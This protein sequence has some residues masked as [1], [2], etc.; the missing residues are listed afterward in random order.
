MQS[1]KYVEPVIDAERSLSPRKSRLQSATQ[2][3]ARRLHTAMIAKGMNQSDLARATWKK[4]TVDKR[5]YSQPVGKDRI[6]VYLKGRVLPDAQNLKRLA[7]ALDMKV[8]DLAPVGGG[9]PVDRDAPDF[10]FSPAA[11]GY[12]LVELKYV[13]PAEDAATIMGIIARLEAEKDPHGQKRNPNDP[14]VKFLETG[15]TFRL[16]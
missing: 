3:F 4:D 11:G 9:A 5:G 2:E 12:M 10:V 1:P 14:Q 7:D 6:S 16:S 15:A 8:E 13:M